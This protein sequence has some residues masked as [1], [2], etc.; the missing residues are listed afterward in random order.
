M[1]D[2]DSPGN[3]TALR[4]AAITYV[5]YPCRCC[6]GS[7]SCEIS[8]AKRNSGSPT[9]RYYAYLWVWAYIG[10]DHLAPMWKPGQD[11]ACI[12]LSHIRSLNVTCLLNLDTPSVTRKTVTFRKT[13]GV[14]LAALSNELS[15]SDLCK[16]T[17]DTLRDL[18][19]CYNTTLSSA[20]DRHAP[21]VK[22]S[23]GQ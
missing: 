22:P 16:N 17:P 19:D 2:L 10:S 12:W 18:V 4:C 11:N 5:W 9:G 8:W 7:W 23:M 1:Q 15:S 13:K 6:W 14:D 21:L 3:G 20:L